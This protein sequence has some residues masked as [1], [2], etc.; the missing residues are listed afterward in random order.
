MS[1]VYWKDCVAECDM[2]LQKNWRDDPDNFISIP[3]TSCHRQLRSDLLLAFLYE[4]GEYN[5]HHYLADICIP[6]IDNQLEW[7]VQ[8][9]DAAVKT[10]APTVVSTGAQAVWEYVSNAVHAWLIEKEEADAEEARRE[11]GFH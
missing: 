8:L 9:M 1:E 10:D 5:Q 4:V 6:V 2:S 7:V 3:I 11:G